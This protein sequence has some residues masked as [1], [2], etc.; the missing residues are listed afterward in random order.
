MEAFP[1]SKGA[2]RSKIEVGCEE[3]LPVGSD[4]GKEEGSGVESRKLK[5]PLKENEPDLTEASTEFDM[6][7]LDDSREKTKEPDC[8]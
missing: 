1:K 3:G 2:M 5:E 6:G 7:L 8:D 4:E